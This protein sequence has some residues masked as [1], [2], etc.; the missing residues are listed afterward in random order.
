M[1]KAREI[2]QERFA[3]GEITAE[4]FDAVISRLDNNA[5]AAPSQGISQPERPSLTDSPSATIQPAVNHIVGSEAFEYVGF[6]PRVGAALIDTLLILLLTWPLLTLI[7][8]MSY[9]TS[10]SLVQGPMDFY[11]S[12][13]LPAI[14]VILFWIKT[15]ATPGKKVVSAKIVDAR[16]GN[17]AST[18]Q[19]VGR[20][21][22][23]YLSMLPLGLGLIWVAFDDRKQGWHDK[24]AGTIVIRP[25]NRTPKAVE[26][27]G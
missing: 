19:L 17:A 10:D 25:K 24:I 18:G 23:Y 11:L 8:G 20:Y 7:Y 26:F 9:W 2:A 22:A 15:Q 1:S 5:S 27:G 16:T 13:V 3:K 6:W 12:F 4:E 14:L 21:F